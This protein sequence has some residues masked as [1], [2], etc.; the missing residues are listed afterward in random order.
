MKVERFFEKFDAFV[1]LPGAPDRLR[2]LI[3]ALAVRGRI[4]HAAPTT[5]DL[6]SS[7]RTILDRTDLTAPAG[8][9]DPEG[10][11]QTGLGYDIP[12]S[13]KWAPLGQL[14]AFGPTNGV[15]P[16]PVD[17]ETPVRSL[18]LSATT[19]GR[20]IDQFFKYIDVEIPLDS[21]LWLEDGDILVQRGNT[22]EH[23][24][25]AA[26]YRGEPHRF[27]YPDLMM[28]LRLSSAVDVRF[29]HLAMSEG[30]ARNFLRAR[31]SGTSGSMPKINQATLRSLPIPLPPLA[32][33]KRIAAKVEELMKLCD[34]LEAQQQEREAR[35]GTLASASLTRFSEDP[36]PASVE[37]LFH[38]SYDIEPG[39]LRNA[40]LDLAVQG[41]LLRQE[42]GNRDA[43]RQAGS[44][45][46]KTGLNPR[47]AA[48]PGTWTVRVLAEIA[49]EIVDCPHSTPKWTERGK[50]CVRTSQFRPGS[51]DLS[52][53]RFVSGETF[54]SR[55]VRL[56]P[57]QDDVLYSREGGILGVACRVPRGV[58]LCLGQ[59]MLL[60][61]AGKDVT[62]EFLE[63]V[64]NSPCITKLARRNTTGSAAPRVNVSTVRA[65]SIPLPPL[66]E[67][68]R[69]V[70]KA[71]QLM[72]L[73]DDLQARLVASRANGEKLL[74]A[75]VAEMTEGP[76][77]A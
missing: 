1:R 23:V 33:Q 45:T 5:P 51:L 76:R 15:S 8:S 18:T 62:P 53:S 52:E 19:S 66:V 41:R 32:Q 54:A 75:I 22:L 11:A 67:Q 63:L 65:Y 71:D 59:R 77:A 21:D 73:I 72:A 68:R 74:E 14:L 16:R 24:G 28:K 34:R 7:R 37:F 56:R 48:L 31:A 55:I 10:H 2:R 27:V 9:E 46:S 69:I 35:H 39:G 20:F 30:T 26:I 64:L 38:R 42:S 36:T 57:R 43:Q 12:K 40:V 25:V 70:A 29:V 17:F 13:W 47:E 44:F 58:E 6:A 50:I 61:R 49:E 3:L 4:A 60:I